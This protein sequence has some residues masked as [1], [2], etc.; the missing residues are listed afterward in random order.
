MLE[1][2]P[3]LSIPDDEL[4]ERF[5]RSSGP[6]GQ[7]VNKVNTKA[8]L[9]WQPGEGTVPSP[10]WNRFRVLAKRYLTTEGEVVIQS[11]QFRDQAQ[12]VQ[13]CRTRLAELL[14]QASV[15][16]KRRIKTKPSKAAKRR[17]LDEKKRNSEKKDSRR[18][19]N[20]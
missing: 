11:Q 10:V 12:N 16:P 9:R 6:G 3:A 13:A 4:V 19:K 14:R 5:V 17:R 1:I 2:S 8:T 18:P 15:A 20:W 7:N